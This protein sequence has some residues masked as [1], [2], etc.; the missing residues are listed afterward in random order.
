MLPSLEP[1][2]TFTLPLFEFV[3][4]PRPHIIARFSRDF[5]L[6]FLPCFCGFCGRALSVF[7]FSVKV[8]RVILDFVFFS[9]SLS[10][11]SCDSVSAHQRFISWLV[12]LSVENTT[13]KLSR[14]GSPPSVVVSSNNNS[15]VLACRTA[16]R[17]AP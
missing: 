3:R 1:P 11:I 7:P 2:R 12:R 13:K 5:I 8:E 4:S 15:S 9:I 6:S 10:I 16:R 14:N 17:S